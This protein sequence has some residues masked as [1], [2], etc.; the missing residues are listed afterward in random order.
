MTFGTL[1]KCDTHPPLCFG[2]QN[3]ACFMFFHTKLQLN[4]TEFDLLNLKV[5]HER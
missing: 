4:L 1:G 3:S 5:Y 2:V